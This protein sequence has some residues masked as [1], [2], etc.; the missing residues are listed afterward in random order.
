MLAVALLQRLFVDVEVVGVRHD[1]LTG[2][3][4][5]DLG[6]RLVALLGLDVVP[7]LR[8]LL[9]AELSL[10]A[11]AEQ[12]IGLTGSGSQIVH[13][14]LRRVWEYELSTQSHL[15]TGLAGDVLERMLRAQPAGEGD[16]AP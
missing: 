15:V 8:Q 7:E 5:A 14:G 12:I 4:H 13:E 10:L 3:Q 11:L 9:V 1:E 2:T 16:T 6:P